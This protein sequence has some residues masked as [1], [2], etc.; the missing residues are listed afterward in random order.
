MNESLSQQEIDAL[1]GGDGGVESPDAVAGAAPRR[2]KDLQ[3]YD[4]GRPARIS[5][6][7]KRSLVAIYD[8]VG[9][10]LE[11]WLTGRCRDPVEMEV[12][13]VEVMTFAEFTLALRSPCVSYIVDLNGPGG[14]QG[15]IDFGH[16]LAFYVVDR[17]LG[18]SGEV[19]IPDRGLTP[20]ERLI[21]K[22]VAERVSTQ[23]G[24]AWNDYVQLQ[25]QVG[26]FESIP[27]MIQ[28]S[29]REDPVLVTHVRVRIGSMT[30]T[31]LLSLPF[32]VLERFFTGDSRRKMRRIEGSPEERAEDRVQLEHS[33]LDAAV[34]VAARLPDLHLP[35]SALAALKA[36][37]VVPTG[38]PPDTPIQIRVDEQV[39]FLGVAG[40]SGPKIGVRITD[41]V[42]LESPVRG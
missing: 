11:G 9:K 6:D 30:S 31:L 22:I 18:G 35:L 17:L 39:R 36:G 40:R 15:V 23:V 41:T 27:E 13:S 14:Q 4:F 8:V 26:G 10:A 29:N 25:P 28:A 7:Q 32:P 2:N 12:E 19:E 24:E 21:L 34:D 1:F 33:V 38:H 37:E 3:V 20:M 5:K 42:S 16:E